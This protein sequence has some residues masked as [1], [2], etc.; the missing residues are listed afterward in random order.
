MIAA[1]WNKSHVQQRESRRKI[2]SWR[3][4]R[5]EQAESLK[6]EASRLARRGAAR[7]G[8]ILSTRARCDSA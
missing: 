5:L 4:N 1:I 7:R 2:S 8:T 3:L 6:S